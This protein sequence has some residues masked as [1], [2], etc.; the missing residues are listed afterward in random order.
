MIVLGEYKH[1][2]KSI[3]IFV[4]FKIGSAI[5]KSKQNSF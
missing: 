3:N 2:K 1:D 4:L 5:K